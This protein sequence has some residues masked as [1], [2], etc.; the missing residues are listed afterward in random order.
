MHAIGFAYSGDWNSD[1]IDFDRHPER[2]WY[3]RE[4]PPVIFAK[5]L[6]TQ[7]WQKLAALL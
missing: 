4:S 2:V 7:M 1:L 3:W 6:C 5:Q